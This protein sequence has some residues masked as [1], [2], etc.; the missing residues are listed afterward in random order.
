MAYKYIILIMM[1]MIIDL[2]AENIFRVHQLSK[3]VFNFPVN[4][5]FFVIG[6]FLIKLVMCSF[7]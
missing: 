6:N 2:T 5:L 4:S 3:N 7:D 1:V